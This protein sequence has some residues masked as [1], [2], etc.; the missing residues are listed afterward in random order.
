M[1]KSDKKFD[2]ELRKSLT[3]LCDNELKCIDGFEWLT[4]TV[5]FSN[6]QASLKIVCVFD[7]NQHLNRFLSSS[8]KPKVESCILNVISDLN[9]KLKK[10]SKQ[11][12]FDSEENCHQF[13]YGNWAVRLS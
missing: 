9:I 3:S 7:T 11:L 13:N 8:E 6:I 10:P 5:N 4:H 12:V 2:N 1:K